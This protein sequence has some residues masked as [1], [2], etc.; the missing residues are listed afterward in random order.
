MNAA[1]KSF[2]NC[3]GIVFRCLLALLLVCPATPLRSDELQTVTST[4]DASLS[5]AAP[6]VNNGT[7]TT[8]STHTAQNANQRALVRFDL[9]TTGLNSNTALKTSTL[10]LVTV[11]P[12]FTGRSQEVHRI[13]GT[14]DWTETGVTWNTRN[15]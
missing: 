10:N 1:F 3:S 13:I 4:R 15:G 6:A 7:G 9:T 11:T 12:L 2:G 8:M 5:Q 14:T